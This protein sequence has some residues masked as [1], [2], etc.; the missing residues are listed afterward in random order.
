MP[1]W[2]SSNSQSRIKHVVLASRYSFTNK[3]LNLLINYDVN[4]LREA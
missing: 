2:L 4:Y 3:G 1:S